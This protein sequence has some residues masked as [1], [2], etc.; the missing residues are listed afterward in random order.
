[1]DVL[2]DFFPDV[3]F[4]RWYFF[5]HFSAPFGAAAFPVTQ[6]FQQDTP[7]LFDGL[8]MALHRV[9]EAHHQF[10]LYPLDVSTLVRD[11]PVV[12]AG[13]RVVPQHRDDR[14]RRNPLGY[15]NRRQRFDEGG[16]RIHIVN[17]GREFFHLLDQQLVL[18]LRDHVEGVFSQ[19]AGETYQPG[20]QASQPQRGL[21]APTMRGGDENHAFDERQGREE[22]RAVQ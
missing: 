11:D 22:Q 16:R 1:M 13:D 18:I 12:A 14:M 20:G 9:A 17:T 15:R 6:M 21:I 2:P 5:A 19:I 7:D 10:R 8:R 4:S 3:I